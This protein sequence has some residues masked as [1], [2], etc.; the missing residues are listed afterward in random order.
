MISKSFEILLFVIQGGLEIVGSGNR[1]I[2]NRGFNL[3]ILKILEI[4]GCLVI[5]GL[6]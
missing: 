1:V 6:T 2:S 5:V 3:L 4:V